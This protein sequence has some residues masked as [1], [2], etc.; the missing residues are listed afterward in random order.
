ML[1]CATHDF[2]SF[3]SLL[4]ASLCQNAFMWRVTAETYVFIF[5]VSCVCLLQCLYTFMLSISQ[6]HNLALALAVLLSD[7]VCVRAYINSVGFLSNSIHF[8]ISFFVRLSL[9]F[10]LRMD[11][12]RA[13]VSFLDICP[14]FFQLFCRFI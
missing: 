7:S 5:A 3:F 12:Q 13:C 6:S 9:I 11:E 1:M 14:P 8:T 4:L 2:L 10:P